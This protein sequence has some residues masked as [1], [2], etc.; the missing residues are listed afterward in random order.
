MQCY[1]LSRLSSEMLQAPYMRA[2]SWG[3]GFVS[4]RPCMHCAGWSDAERA[5]FEVRQQH[6]SSQTSK[7]S[8]PLAVS[9][10]EGGLGLLSSSDRPL[11]SFS[12]QVPDRGVS[13]GAGV[14]KKKSK[15]RK[16][17]ASASQ[18]NRVGWGL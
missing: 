6:R 9:P 8:S 17:A 13:K 14:V 2:N 3:G 7:R 11:V 18:S 12:L 10:P 15:K 4:G 5:A 16:A 1:L